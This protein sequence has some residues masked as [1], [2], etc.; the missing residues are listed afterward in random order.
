MCTVDLSL[1]HLQ[2]NLARST[3]HCS[4]YHHPDLCTEKSIGFK[5]EYVVVAELFVLGFVYFSCACVDVRTGLV[6]I[7]EIMFTLESL[8]GLC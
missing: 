7:S 6:K 3:T 2:C 8:Q 1:D 5:I 4:P